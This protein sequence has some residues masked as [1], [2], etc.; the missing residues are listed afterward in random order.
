[1]IKTE[2]KHLTKVP[3]V[4]LAFLVVYWVYVSI[5]M[6]RAAIMLTNGAIKIKKK[7]AKIVSDSLRL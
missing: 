3:N 6:C 4:R 2:K 1:M 7:E 5:N